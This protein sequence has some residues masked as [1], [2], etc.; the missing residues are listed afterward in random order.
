[1]GT[2]PPGGAEP[3]PELLLR[4]ADR[5][6]AYLLR[7]LRPTGRFVYQRSAATGRPVPGSYNLLRHFGSLWAIQDVCGPDPVVG[8]RV[9]RAVDWAVQRYYVRTRRGGAFRKQDGLVTG[10]SGLALL[11]LDRLRLTHEPAEGD[12][13]RAEIVEYLLANQIT[14][15][16]DDL[17][18]D[19]RH[20]ICLDLPVLD[21]VH[22]DVTVP[23]EVSEFRSNYYTGEILFG[24]LTQI[25]GPGRDELA[26]RVH[27]V[28]ARSMTA[29]R[30]RDYGVRER[31]HWMMYAIR[32]FC[33]VQDLRAG[34]AGPV[35]AAGPDT[36]APWPLR[37]EMTTW[38]SRIARS[39]VR[40]TRGGRRNERSAPTACRVEAQVQYLG[41]IGSGFDERPELTAAV[42]RQV[43]EDC[44]L[45]LTLQDPRTG[46]FPGSAVDP[47]M[48]IDYTQHAISG[49]RGAALTDRLW[50]GAALS[51]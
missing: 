7:N 1:M 20:K 14:D 35:P 11:A 39:I 2:T 5:G 17:R 25:A 45:L 29:L 34:T 37:V 48:Q 19:F 47:I 40:S 23:P 21:A 9:A 15:A 30:A 33:V 4:A 46:G 44:A 18:Y 26:E 8:A 49:L 36:A 51:R 10:C 22:D 50:T 16:G 28:A 24:L 12:G 27:A 31:S 41:L 42:T 38:A 3:T 32:Q 43:W 6:A 13:F